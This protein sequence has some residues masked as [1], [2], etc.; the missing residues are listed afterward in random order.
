M[1]F[2]DRHTNKYA[3]SIKTFSLKKLDN[4]ILKN[5]RNYV[6][7]MFIK[8]DREHQQKVT[9]SDFKSAIN[10]D[11][12]M[13][14]IFDVLNKGLTQTTTESQKNLEYDLF[15]RA[16]NQVKNSLDMMILELQGDQFHLRKYKTSDN[17]PTQFK[18]KTQTFFQRDTGN[19]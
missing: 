7:Q 16:L 5:I 4:E 13:L 10:E 1:G 17:S 18:V 9:L 6:K 15:K 2:Y 19:N 14:E 12:N 3:I 8:M 11:P